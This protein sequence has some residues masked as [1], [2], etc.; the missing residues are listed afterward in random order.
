MRD[1]ASDHDDGE[2]CYFQFSPT[3]TAYPD[4]F[5]TYPWPITTDQDGKTEVKQP[6]KQTEVKQPTDKAEPT[7][8]LSAKVSTLRETS[9]GQFN[10]YRIAGHHKDSRN[11]ERG[12]EGGSSKA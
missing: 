3:S 10:N 4:P 8:K 12:N 7:N 9:L 2:V 1:F 11:V 6:E 5:H